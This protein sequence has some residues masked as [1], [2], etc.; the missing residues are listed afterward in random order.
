MRIESL[1]KFVREDVK[2]NTDDG[3]SKVVSYRY[4]KDGPASAEVLIDGKDWLPIRELKVIVDAFY[5]THPE[6]AE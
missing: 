6:A 5:E 1:E 4:G 2:L 3:C